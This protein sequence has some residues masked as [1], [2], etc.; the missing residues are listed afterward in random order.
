M[1]RCVGFAVTWPGVKHARRC[2][3]Q[4]N[5]ALTLH[6]HFRPLIAARLAMNGGEH[7]ATRPRLILRATTWRGEDAPLPSSLH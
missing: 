1:T 6:S 7:L 3:K 4:Q 2:A 5:G